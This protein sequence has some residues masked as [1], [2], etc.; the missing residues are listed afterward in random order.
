[1]LPDS[2]LSTT[3]VPAQFTYP[4]NI[5]KQPLIDYEYGGYDIGDA[6][7]GLRV[8]VWKAEFVEGEILVS[9][10]DR[11]PVAIVSIADPVRDI[12]LA[13]DQHMQPFLTWE[14]EDG[15][16][17]YRWFDPLIPGF[18]ITQLPSDTFTPRCCIDDTRDTLVREGQSDIILAY[19]RHVSE[20]SNLY[21]R[22]E[23]E[24][25]QTEHLLLEGAGPAGLI[26]IGM[27]RKLRMQFQL[28]TASV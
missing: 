27:N 3:A 11:A 16:C 12:G 17:F 20:N 13:F 10:I 22:A 26:Q 6:S 7:A 5:P 15:R 2:V 23:R 1:M 14:L 18:T 28:S 8:K 9:A 24:R 4:R 21:F 19:C 25:Y